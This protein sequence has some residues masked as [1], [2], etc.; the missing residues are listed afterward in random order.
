MAPGCTDRVLA[1]AGLGVVGRFLVGVGDA[2]AEGRSLVRGVLGVV[3]GAVG[4][5][6]V[7]ITSGGGDAAGRC[8]GFLGL[9]SLL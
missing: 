2:G 3:L 1:R 4:L 8:L 7:S 9:G 6:K 5:P